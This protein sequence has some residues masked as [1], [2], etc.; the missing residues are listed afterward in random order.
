MRILFLH[1]LASSG[2]Y[3]MA[4]MLRGL[5]APCEVVAPD[6]PLDPD[7][8]FALLNEICTRERPDLVVGL[9]WGGF[10][11]LRIQAA[12]TVAVNPELRVSNFM[13]P[14][15]GRME[16]LS[17]RKDGALTFDITEDICDRYALIERSA[18]EKTVPL[19]GCF[20]DADDVAHCA[21]EFESLYPGCSLRSPGGHLPNYR[22]MKSF[23]VPAIRNFITL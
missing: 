10:L 19:L 4:D 8:V 20:G 15:I 23:I 16:Y 9:S 22:E 13:R 5:L 18:P 12:P 1:G 17:P 3:K 6:L 2:A 14:R 11:A 21:D 7:E